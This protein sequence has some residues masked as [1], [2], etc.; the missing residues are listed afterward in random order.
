MPHRSPTALVALVA[1][2]HLLACESRTPQPPASATPASTAST[3]ASAT[4]Q[5]GAVATATTAT[6]Y[7][8]PTIRPPGTAAWSALRGK[9]DRVQST[10]DTGLTGA[11]TRATLD[12]WIAC[13]E[14]GGAADAPRLWTRHAFELHRAFKRVDGSSGDATVKLA[15][16]TDT[17]VPLIVVGSRLQTQARGAKVRARAIFQLSID[18]NVGASEIEFDATGR[19]VR[20]TQ[21]LPKDRLAELHNRTA[22]MAALG[23]A[24]EQSRPGERRPVECYALPATSPDKPGRGQECRAVAFPPAQEAQ[25]VARQAASKAAEDAWIASNIDEIVLLS[26]RLYS[27]EDANCRVLAGGKL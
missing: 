14:R 22:L 6:P 8:A 9:D 19:T 15:P 23:A 25:F 18:G 11:E 13:W 5:P 21:S 1:L 7:G 3:I 24:A 27:F 26:K 2:A 20:I 12:K 10:D 16:T 17:D 4:A